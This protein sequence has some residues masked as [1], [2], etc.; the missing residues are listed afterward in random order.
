[1]VACSDIKG[2]SFISDYELNDLGNYGE[3][4]M[5]DSGQSCKTIRIDDLDLP[6]PDVIKIDVEGHELK[7]FNGMRQ[8]IRNSK[9]VIMYE[10]MHGTGFDEIYDF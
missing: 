3:C 4:M 10:A 6:K 7:V 5:T 8:T 2:D 9:P 1:A